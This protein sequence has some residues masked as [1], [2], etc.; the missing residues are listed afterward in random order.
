MLK[1]VARILLSSQL[2]ISLHFGRRNRPCIA[3][4]ARCINHL[5]AQCNDEAVHAGEAGSV[6]AIAC[7]TEV[8]ATE[9]A[10]TESF[11]DEFFHTFQTDLVAE[12]I[13]GVILR[14]VIGNTG[15][16]EGVERVIGCFGVAK[17]K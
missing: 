4:V 5:S 7:E 10:Q 6:I 8:P 17:F 16:A 13:A 3:V 12:H 2:G 14:S 11:T 1:L 15:I 9:V